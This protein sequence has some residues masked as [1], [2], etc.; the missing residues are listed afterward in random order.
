MGL[1]RP[2]SPAP[3]EYHDP[4]P[5]HIQISAHPER[6]GGSWYSCEPCEHL[7]V[8]IPG[9]AIPGSPY[10]GQNW[11]LRQMT[12]LGV[13]KCLFWGSLL[14]PF[15][16]VFWGIKF[17]P[18]I[19]RHFLDPKKCHLPEFPILTSVGGPWDRKSWTL[20]FPAPIVSAETAF[21]HVDFRKE[22]PS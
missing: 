18:L 3:R 7:S 13:K 11:K 16:W 4:P 22:F 17:P 21:F 9:L 6:L 19:L 12:F 8:G 15:K 2:S 1:S 20:V 14:E 5:S 10:R